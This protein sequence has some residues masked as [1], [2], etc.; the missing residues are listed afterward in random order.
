MADDETLSFVAASFDSIWALELLLTLKRAGG[1]C[2]RTDLKTRMHASE[3]VVAQALDSLVTAG[4]IS[5]DSDTAIFMPAS[6]SIAASVE[7][8]EELYHRRP[9]AVRRAIIIARSS[10][11]AAFAE[12][13]RLR[14][15]K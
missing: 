12:A 9:D 3:T 13:F 6:R 11:V 10:G 4:L 15:G 5:N 14:K 2:T 8:A 7:R 1:A